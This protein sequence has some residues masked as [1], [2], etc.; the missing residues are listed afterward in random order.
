MSN[1][2]FL[3]LGGITVVLTGMFATTSLYE[4]FAQE[5]NSTAPSNQTRTGIP[6]LNGSVNVLEQY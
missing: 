6:Q 3:V 1:K 4:I 5:T 2:Q